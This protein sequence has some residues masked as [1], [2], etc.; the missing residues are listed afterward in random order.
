[1]YIEPTPLNLSDSGRHLGYL[2]ITFYTN[3]TLLFSE[4]KDNLNFQI[5]IGMGP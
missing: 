3:R 5:F 1:M 4:T 2:Y